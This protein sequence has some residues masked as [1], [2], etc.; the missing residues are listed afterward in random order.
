MTGESSAD[1]VSLF[2]PSFALNGLCASGACYKMCTWDHAESLSGHHDEVLQL[3][4]T[5]G[6]HLA[7]PVTLH[8]L[9]NRGSALILSAFA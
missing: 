6:E 8:Q 3:F 9:R 1:K 2:F 4:P 5:T 7:Q